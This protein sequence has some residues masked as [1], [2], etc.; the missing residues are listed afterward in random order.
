[1]NLVCSG[2]IGSLKDFSVSLKLGQENSV[3]R[4]LEIPENYTAPIQRGQIIGKVVYYLDN[5]I[6]GEN[7]IIALE[8]APKKEV[9]KSGL[10]NSL[11]E[12]FSKIFGSKNKKEIQ[13]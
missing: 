6:I 11:A 5:T 4:K 7:E 1:M 8:D 12:F 9:K 2:R 10:F 13:V 3:V